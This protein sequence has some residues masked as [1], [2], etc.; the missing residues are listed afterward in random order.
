MVEESNLVVAEFTMDHPI[1]RELLK[2]VTDIELSWGMTHDLPDGPTQM[3]AWIESDDFEAV[4][5]ALENDP[6][7]KNATVLAVLSERRLYRV[8]FTEL[9]HE[10]DILPTVVESGGIIQQVTATKEA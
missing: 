3:T 9:G 2:S 1:F 5:T 8:D 6:T 10:T 4:E 7:T